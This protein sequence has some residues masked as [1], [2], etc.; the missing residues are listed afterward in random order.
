MESRT[1]LTRE[2]VGD[3]IASVFQYNGRSPTTIGFYD[4]A[5]NVVDFVAEVACNVQGLKVRT[6][7][8]GTEYDQ[9][10]Q[11]TEDA[12]GRIHDKRSQ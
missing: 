11:M 7:P 6:V 1:R 5:G 10:R 4:A 2:E 9:L 12:I 8:E 3:I